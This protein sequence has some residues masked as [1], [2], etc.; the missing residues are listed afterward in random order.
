M[1][2]SK[3][4]FPDLAHLHIVHLG[5]SHGEFL[6]LPALQL[7]HFVLLLDLLLIARSTF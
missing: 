3:Q 1:S 2:D 6:Y 7:Q 4:I 5:L